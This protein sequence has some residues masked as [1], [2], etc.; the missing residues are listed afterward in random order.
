MPVAI[1]TGASTGI[2]A[3]LAREL[4]RRGHAVGLVARRLELLEELAVE[5]R[6]AGG[7]A[8]AAAADVTDRA[9][10][11]RAIRSIEEAL[12]PCDLMIANAGAGNP[13]PAARAPVETILDTMR[14]NYDGVVHAVFAVVPAMLAR[15]AG[16][17]AV[18]SSVAG[19]RGL[20]TH[21]GYCASKSAISTLFESLRME[22]V[23]AGV[24]VTTIHP[25][26]VETPLTAKN[27]FPMPFIMSSDRA[28][29]IIA[30]GL[31]RRRT[32]ITFPWQLRVLMGWMLR[33]TP[34]WLWDLAVGG[35][36]RKY[37]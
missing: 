18:V 26:F 17:V 10:T 36:A 3:A 29:R 21:G 12:G 9:A 32:D 15:K 14:L 7:K 37:K 31:A 35:P 5:I 16:H 4:A 30:D 23:P 24:H 34:N 6:T 19:F 28:A 22:L 33:W 27:T 25:G 1:I 20:P 13:T 8:F 2:G 11:E